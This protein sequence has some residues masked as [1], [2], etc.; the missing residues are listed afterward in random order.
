MLTKKNGIAISLFSLTLIAAACSPPRRVGGGSYYNNELANMSTANIA[1]VEEN[2]FIK[3]IDSATSTFSIDADGASYTLTRR[4]LNGYADFNYKGLRTEEMVNYF[5]YNYEDPADDAPIGVNGEVST[6]PWNTAHK[7]IRIGIKGKSIPKEQYPLANFVLLID[8][9]GSMA[10]DDKLS[11]LKNGFTKFVNHMR[12]QD[13]I[14]IVTYSGYQSLALESTPGTE[15]VKIIKA[16]NKLGSAGGTNGSGGITLAYQIARQNFI[17]NGNNR[18]IM[19]TDG[20]FNVGITSMDEVIKLVTDQRENGIFLTTLGVGIDNIN[21]AMLEQ[22]ANKG[23]GNYEYLDN[24]DELNKVFVNDYSKFLTVAKDVKVQVT[25][26]KEVVENYRLIGY[27]NRVMESKQFNNDQ[28][29]AGEIGAGQTITA[30]YE[31]EPKKNA[32]VSTAPTFTIHFRYK[33]PEAA[34]SIPLDLD[35]FDAGH[36]FESSS[37]NMRFAASVAAL[38]LYLRD[39]RYKGSMTLEQIKSWSAG[40]VSFDP[41]GYRAQHLELL[42][43]VK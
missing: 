40:A 36:S 27:E 4:K 41:N 42:K 38:G 34:V 14:A 8:V 37:E 7:L 20:D 35:I 12:P 19:G 15:K 43:I 18:V 21:D 39:S 22:L 30:I 3:T 13:R 1:T 6:C 10:S 16:I 26:N 2:P 9:S 28:A 29:D 32:A 25:F 31:I 11:L 24:H 5:T 23:N 33:K 17:P